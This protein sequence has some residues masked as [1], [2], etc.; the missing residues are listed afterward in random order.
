[1]GWRSDFVTVYSLA[2]TELGAPDTPATAHVRT[3]AHRKF[4]SFHSP[5]QQLVQTTTDIR[6]PKVRQIAQNSR[7]EVVWWFPDTQEQFRLSGRAYVLPSREFLAG[8]ASDEGE[9][10][11]EKEQQILAAKKLY[12]EFVDAQL[13]TP[14]FDWEKARFDSFE[15]M[16]PY[17]RAT[18]LRPTPGTLLPNGHDEAKKWVQTLPNYEEANKEGNEKV[19]ENWEKACRNFALVVIDPAEVDYVELGVKPNR[20]SVFKKGVGSDK[21]GWNE[22]AVVP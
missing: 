3:I 6:T 21:M 18:W 20:R 7:V 16:N 2:T 17:M 5:A 22:L 9:D 19:K 11:G 1:M 12:R 4:L 8:D 13:A 15:S 14:D 10:V